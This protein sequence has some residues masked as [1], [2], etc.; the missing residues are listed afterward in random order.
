MTSLIHQSHVVLLLHRISLFLL[1]LLHRLH[2]EHMCHALATA[3]PRTLERRSTVR[4][5]LVFTDGACED[6]TSVGGFALFPCGAT[7]MFGAVVPQELA[8][9]WRSRTHQSQVIGQAELYPL[10][11][12]RLTW[13]NR[14]RGQRAV[15]FV[16]NESA[17]L[18]AIKAYSPILASTRIL[19]EISLFDHIHEVYPWYASP[20]SATGRR[21]L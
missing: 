1:E 20:I 8:D 3:S 7:E 2:K 18:A 6:V 21:V 16:D 15:F 4:P 14:I 11:A 13:A 9:Q 5:A 10:L 12:A 19:A 17:R